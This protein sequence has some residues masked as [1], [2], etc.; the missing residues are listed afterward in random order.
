MFSVHQVSFRF[1]DAKKHRKYDAGLNFGPGFWEAITSIKAIN[2]D[3]KKLRRSFLA[4]QLFA[5]GDGKRSL[6]VLI[7]L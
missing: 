2:S 3:V 5:S 7:Q 4:M 6:P 1:Y